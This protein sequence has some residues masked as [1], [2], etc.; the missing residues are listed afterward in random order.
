[1]TI[2]AAYAVFQENVIGSLETSKFAD[3]VIIPESPN[4]ISPNGLKDL[5]AVAT[6]VNGEFEYIDDGFNFELQ[7]FAWDKESSSNGLSNLQPFWLLGII[8]VAH[9]KVIRKTKQLS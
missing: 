3:L 9:S 6:M 1:M 8:L 5:Y 7:L 2:D 4:D